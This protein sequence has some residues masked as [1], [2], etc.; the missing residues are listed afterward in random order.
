MK[1]MLQ[2]ILHFFICYKKLYLSIVTSNNK[3]Q[4]KL[5]VAEKRAAHTNHTHNTHKQLIWFR[6]LT[7]T[8]KAMFWNVHAF[9]VLTVSLFYICDFYK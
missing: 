9:V 1:F 3:K 6:F 2:R 8:I 4:C 5:T 7:H